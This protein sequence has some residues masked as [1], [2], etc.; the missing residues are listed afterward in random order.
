[1]DPLAAKVARRFLGAEADPI[2]SRVARRYLLAVAPPGKG[3]EHVVKELKKD[4]EVDNP[5]ALA[6]YMKN[7]GDKT[8][9][10]DE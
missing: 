10:K 5:F 9:K 7:K 2:V 3:W 6:W 1:M 8:H 4:D